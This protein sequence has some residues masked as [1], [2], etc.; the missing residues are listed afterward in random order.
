M[1]TWNVGGTSLSQHEEL[2]TR[3]I[4]DDISEDGDNYDFDL[5][6]E[7]QFNRSSQYIPSGSQSRHNIDCDLNEHMSFMSKEAT[8]NAIK[9]YHID[10]GYKFVVVESKPNRYVA[11]CIHHD[12]GCEWR[13][14]A[15][16]SKIRSQWE[17]KKIDAQH[18]CLSTN[19]VIPLAI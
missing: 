3:D 16:F 12:G 15:S 19:D 10:N 17:I 6:D 2:I 18:S 14:R 4:V 8:L 5:D 7:D 11:R 13:L 9:W 1:D